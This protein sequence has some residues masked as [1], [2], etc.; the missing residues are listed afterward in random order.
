MNYLYHLYL[1]HIYIYTPEK[2]VSMRPKLEGGR[3]GVGGWGGGRGSG[4]G[5]GWRGQ[6]A[7][8]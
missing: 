8:K 2:T 7:L 5:G 4:V 6:G 3:A 1:I